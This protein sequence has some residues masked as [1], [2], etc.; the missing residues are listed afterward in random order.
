M[1]FEPLNKQA[2][3]VA[4]NPKRFRYPRNL[5]EMIDAVKKGVSPN[6]SF[7]QEQHHFKSVHANTSKRCK[8]KRL[9]CEKK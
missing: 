1:M 9:Y 4:A 5:Y 2:F 8:N 7:F 6:C 3:L